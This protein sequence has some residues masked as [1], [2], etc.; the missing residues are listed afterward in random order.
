M[1]IAE[2]RYNR[3]RLREAQALAGSAAARLLR[4]SSATVADQSTYCKTIRHFRHFDAENCRNFL[5]TT[6]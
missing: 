4:L 2:Q 6:V 1:F 3:A 5:Q